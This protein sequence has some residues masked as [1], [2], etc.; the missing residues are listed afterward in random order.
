MAS[1]P[2]MNSLYENAA[3]A[4]YQNPANSGSRVPVPKFANGGRTDIALPV[5]PK[6]K[7]ING[8]PISGPPQNQNRRYVMG[9]PMMPRIRPA[10]PGGF[11]GLPNPAGAPMPQPQGMGG[12]GGLP[13]PGSM[14]MPQ[15]AIQGPYAGMPN[16]MSGFGGLANPAGN[17]A[18][19]PV[20]GFGN[21][22]AMPMMRG[23]MSGFGAMMP[24][25]MPQQPMPRFQ[26]VPQAPMLY[27]PWG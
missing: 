24:S 15:P 4:S 10:M 1:K 2:S 8:Q 16:P 12:F 26:Q 14:P 18:T 9:R 11:G 13:N 3:G 7:D 19:P 22:G 21:F 17:V 20:V 27:S 23:G 6:Q 25:V 5:S